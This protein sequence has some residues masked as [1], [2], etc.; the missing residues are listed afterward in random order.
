MSAVEKPVVVVGYE[1][2]EESRDALALARLLVPALGA[3]LYAVAVLVHAPLEVEGPVY[4][5]LVDEET[6]RLESEIREQLGDQSARTLV[7]PAASAAGALHDLA[8]REHAAL[9]VLGSTHRGPLGRVLPG[10]VGERL[11][12]AGPCAVAVAPRGF[13]GRAEPA[14]RSLGVAWT[15][16]MESDRALA[17]AAELAQRAG[18]ALRVLSVVE[19]TSHFAPASPGAV[20]AWSGLEAA[21][22]QAEEE[23]VAERERELAAV[24]AG[25]PSELD[26]S[27]ELLRGDP[28]E[29][30][31]ESSGEL[32]LLVL[33]SRGYGPLRRV[34]L[35]SVS[36]PVLRGADCP[37]V[38]VPRASTAADAGS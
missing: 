21:F 9:I 35:G 10:S 38:V 4:A 1:G 17:L 14:L 19:P 2:R 13:A 11:L 12:A 27:S 5:R 22:E 6:E 31:I 24:L 15:A 23:E 34:L 28:V 7:V 32:D 3:E 16:G 30:L 18:C 20:G 29:R 33:G 8:E 26:A 36:S 25:L 37:V